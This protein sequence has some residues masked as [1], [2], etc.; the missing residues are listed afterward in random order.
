M[1]PKDT[2]PVSLEYTQEPLAMPRRRL[3]LRQPLASLAYVDMGEHNGG[4]LLNISEWGLAL[5][6]AQILPADRPVSMR[7]KLPQSKVWIRA[8]GRV[9][10]RSASRKKAGV[11]FADLSEDV[12]EQIREWVYVHASPS[13][14]DARD[15]QPEAERQEASQL[16][17]SETAEAADTL[18]AAAPRAATQA[19]QCSGFAGLLAGIKK[20]FLGEKPPA[21]DLSAEPVRTTEN[22]IQNDL[23]HRNN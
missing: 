8:S 21:W 7:F 12:R 19:T 13:E 18:A 4:I 15:S 10:W 2:M 16:P 6:A 9:V 3:H 5:H 17:D 23:A 20:R 11:C 14:I 1:I 22:G